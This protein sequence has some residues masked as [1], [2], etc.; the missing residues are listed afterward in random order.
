MF[1][2]RIGLDMTLTRPESLRRRL[3][4]LSGPIFIELVLIM[5]LGT[6]DTVMLSQRSDN[7]VAAVGVVAQILNMVFLAFGASTTGASV[8][9]SQYLGARQHKNMMTAVGIALLFNTV[10][11]LFISILLYLYAEPL[12]QLMEL[13]PEL[14][15]EG[16]AYMRIVGGFAFLQA[17]SLTISAILRSA[18][19]A[20]YPMQVTFIINIVNVIGNYT[21]IFGHFGFPEMG[22]TGA[23]LS[24]TFSRAIA[25]LLLL[26]ILYRKGLGTI[27]FSSFSPF[28]WAMLTRMLSIGLPSGGEQ[29]SYSLSQVVIT[30]FTNMLGNEALAARTYAMNIVMFSYVFAMAVGQGGA[31][32]IGHLIGKG[33]KHTAWLLGRYCIKITVLISFAVALLV[34]FSAPHVMGWLSSNPRIIALGILVL[35]IDVI[36]EIG[37]AINILCVNFLRATGDAM[38]PFILGL[39]VMWGV[40]TGFSYLFGIVIGWGLAGMWIAFTMDESIRA[41]LLGRRW[42]SRIW[43]R[44][45]L[46]VRNV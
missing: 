34:A 23:A 25:L 17:L 41:F 16:L 5:L 36:L 11:G 43:E 4:S 2:K 8:L 7:T 29:L 32:C 13:R 46:I 18:D 35:A 38:Y 40:A 26:F 27:P 22:V 30:Y 21:L 1:L 15:D 37:R 10:V 33:H 42:N 45:N 20:Y 39:I 9:C 3:I 31:I 28:P 24:T 44:K 12:L 6:V 14:M 19:M